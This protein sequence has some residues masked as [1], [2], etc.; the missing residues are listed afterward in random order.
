MKY[1]DEYIEYRLLDFKYHPPGN[2]R[3]VDKMCEEGK[4][5]TKNVCVLLSEELVSRWEEK[6]QLL[7]MSKREY[8]EKVL[9]DS[10]QRV[11][12]IENRINP[13]EFLEPKEAD[14]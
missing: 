7:D 6:L 2:E 4:I 9:I 14:A 13:F 5:P 1:F 8:I 10:L 12:E 3:L 11:E